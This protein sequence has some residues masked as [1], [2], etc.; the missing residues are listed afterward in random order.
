MHEEQPSK[1]I[2]WFWYARI[3]QGYIGIVWYLINVMYL[4][5]YYSLHTHDM[6]A[7]V[8]LYM[9]SINIQTNMC[10]L[11]LINIRLMLVISI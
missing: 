3:I 1:A 4:Y 2:I 6:H 7:D 8:L 5:Y 9:S 11:N 10:M